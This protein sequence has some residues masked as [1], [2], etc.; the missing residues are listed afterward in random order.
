MEEESWKAGVYQ[1]AARQLHRK[2][3][4]EVYSLGFRNLRV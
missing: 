3:S 1:Q 4:F 2:A